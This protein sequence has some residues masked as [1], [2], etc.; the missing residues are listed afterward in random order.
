MAEYACGFLVLHYSR[1]SRFDSPGGSMIAEPQLRAFLESFPAF[2]GT[3]PAH[4]GNP[5]FAELSGHFP[6]ALMAVGPP[7]RD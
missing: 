4:G 7:R 5:L 6:L 2:G 1:S 3:L